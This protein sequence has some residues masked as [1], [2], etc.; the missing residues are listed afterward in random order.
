MTVTK[1]LLYLFAM[2]L[3]IGAF[4]YLRGNKWKLGERFTAGIQA[5]E[6]LFLTMA[7]IIV[8]IPC[9]Q[10]LLAPA[11]V[12]A[13]RYLGMDPGLLSGVFIAN[14]MGGYQL[15]HSLAQDPRVGDFSGMLIGSVLGVNLVFTLPAA[16]KMVEKDDRDFMFKGLLFGFITLPLGCLAG[17]LA[18]GFPVLFVLIQLIPVTIIAMISVLML[19]LIPEKLTAV[20]SK[21]GRAIEIIALLGIVSAIV[22]EL[23]G[24]SGKD[25]WLLESIYEGIKIV[26]S[27]IIVLPGAYVFIELLNRC[28]KKFFIKAGEKLAINHVSVLGMITSLAN[29]IPTFLIIKDMDKKGKILNFA[30]LTGGAF[31]FG[32]HLAFCCAVAPKLALPLIVT[33]LT[34][35]FSAL[36]LVSIIYRKYNPSENLK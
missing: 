20:L 12:P 32:D 7:G 23:T 26:G 15:A 25:S 21:I 29:S 19:W 3:I 10:K 16:L 31:A 8:L 13:A 18:A 11:L 27:I 22:G 30:F 5:F 4:D 17:G 28:G 9:F 2:C 14:D 6:P 33:K 34:A 24:F 1:I 36:I 35:A